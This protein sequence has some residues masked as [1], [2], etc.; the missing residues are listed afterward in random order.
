[1]YD[2]LVIADGADAFARLAADGRALE[3]ARDQYRH[4]KPIFACGAA[5]DLLAAAGI[6]QSLPTGEA[7]PAVIV[8]VHG[9]D[10][11]DTF[12]ALLAGHRHFERETDPPRV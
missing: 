9:G 2:A 8:G 7:D 3:F 10:A 6:P 5:A 12:V 11:V 4:C 1:M